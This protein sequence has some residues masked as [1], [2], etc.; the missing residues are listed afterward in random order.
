MVSSS[1]PSLAAV[2][3]ASPYLMT[4]AAS[5]DSRSLIMQSTS[6][7]H[8]SLSFLPTNF[9]SHR[10]FRESSRASR[11][12]AY[13]TRQRP[14]HATKPTDDND[15]EP[16]TVTTQQELL[17][18]LDSKFDYRGRISSKLSAASSTIPH[19]CAL[20]TILGRPNMGKSTLLNALLS[21]DL[22]IATSR[23]QTTRHSI[24]GVITSTHS[25]ICLTDTPGIIEKTAYRL[26]QGMMEA[27][28]AAMR[29]ADVFLIVTDASSSSSDD[30]PS[31]GLGEPVVA[32]L[33]RRRKP[34][35][36]CV[37]K[38][39]LASS[40]E[41]AHTVRKW[42]DL[43]PEAVAIVPACAA[44]GPNDAG[45]VALRSVLLANDPDA[46]VAA[47]MRGLGRPVSGMFRGGRM[48]MDGEEAREMLP[49][50]PPLYGADFFTDRTDRFCAS[51]LIRETLFERLG[52]ELP[53]CCEVRIET[54]DESKRYSEEGDC[55]S[56]DGG[57]RNKS[58]IRIGAVILVERDS[59][60][61]IV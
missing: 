55:G 25:Q 45:V 16:T 2:L 18:T 50:G 51:E 49:V 56:D 37:N 46:D 35:L 12:I 40:D 61:G 17:Q 47:A 57:Q 59:Q 21:D 30:D 26:Q 43:L 60:K 4:V 15:D 29:D 8:A 23:P 3:S 36:V 5:I 6:S 7:R 19:R 39:D 42:R 41:T 1:I 38:I 33:Q 28:R 11:P 10:S 24:L 58:M 27:V 52:K 32:E 48:M 54:F 14:S 13:P 34:V 20:V 22:A 9:P 31:L 44:R 53:Y